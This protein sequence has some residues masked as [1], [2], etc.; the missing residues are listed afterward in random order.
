MNNENK[1]ELRWD[2]SVG[3][4]I[5]K[6]DYIRECIGGLP[7]V[8]MLEEQWAELPPFK[9]GYDCTND[10][11]LHIKRVSA[12]LSDMA[13]EL[14]RRGQ[15]H[16]NSKLGK[17]E[18]PYFDKYTPMLGA[19]P[20]GSEKYKEVLQE[21]RPALQHHYKHNS[22]HPEFYENG[23]E[24]MDLLDVMEMFCDWMGAIRENG[25]IFESINICAERFGISP[26]LKQILINTASRYGSEK[27]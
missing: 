20:F 26:Q 21:M 13:I 15:I 22:H 25:N 23:I 12:H 5:S 16:D 10:V 14:L 24:G 18:K 2:S 27:K 17:K 1:T 7:N 19:V 3:R 9:I 8:S 4:P 6:E 11:L